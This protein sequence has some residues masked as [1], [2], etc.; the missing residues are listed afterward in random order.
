MN[1]LSHLKQRIQNKEYTHHGYVVVLGDG[2]HPQ[3]RVAGGR[4]EIDRVL[5]HLGKVKQSGNAVGPP[6]TRKQKGLEKTSQLQQQRV[7]SSQTGLAR[8][9]D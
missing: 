8:S 1:G 6:Q 5:D 2:D 9:R 3:V 4:H 7:R